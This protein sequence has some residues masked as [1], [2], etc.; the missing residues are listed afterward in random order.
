[1]R[2]SNI[3]I[4]TGCALGVLVG[5]PQGLSV[6]ERDVFTA[7]SAWEAIASVIFGLVAPILIAKRN[8]PREQ[9]S[10]LDTI[11]SAISL[12]AFLVSMC[13]SIAFGG[14]WRLSEVGFHDGK[15]T[16]YY[17]FFA[18]AVGFSAAYYIDRR[19]GKWR[20]R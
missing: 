5:L 12:Y 8:A 20:G 13:A 10:F 19:F 1:M 9:A 17:F 15:P 11:D 7:F 4:A 6:L 2:N 18:A 16:I 3:R 14:F